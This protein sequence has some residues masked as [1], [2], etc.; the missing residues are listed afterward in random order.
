M[1]FEVAPKNLFQVS[2]LETNGQIDLEDRVATMLEECDLV[3]S[4]SLIIDPTSPFARSSSLLVDLLHASSKGC[5]SYIY[6]VSPPSAEYELGP[7]LSRLLLAKQLFDSG[8]LI[9]DLGLDANE[10]QRFSHLHLDPLQPY[11]ASAVVASA[12]ADGLILPT[13]LNKDSRSNPHQHLALSSSMKFATLSAL[14]PFPIPQP[15]FTP[16][17]SLCDVLFEDALLHAHPQLVHIAPQTQFFYYEHALKLKS[18]NFNID[19]IFEHDYS[20]PFAA[21]AVG[22]GLAS[23]PGL[24]VQHDSRARL[25]KDREAHFTLEWARAERASDLWDLY[26]AA[27]RWRAFYCDL[28]HY[29][30]VTYPSITRNSLSAYGAVL[31]S[32]SH[33][34]S[35]GT[36]ADAAESAR[37]SRHVLSLP[38]AAMTASG[39]WIGVVFRSAYE[40]LLARKREWRMWTADAPEGALW[41]G[42]EPDDLLEVCEFAARTADLY[43]EL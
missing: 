1:A 41:A 31:P 33:G 12:L 21:S 40:Q 34:L 32:T 27:P 2:D 43:L 25:S 23:I 4:T 6:T 22:R 29:L 26:V 20:Q 14:L 19:H 36:A 42:L 35:D 13:L 3:S 16:H 5:P 24:A 39:R 7:L 17:G 15:G 38:T 9:V 10:A 8:T 28:P 11:H 37:A 30:P 18:K